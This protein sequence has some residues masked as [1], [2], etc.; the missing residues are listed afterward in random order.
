MSTASGSDARSAA[1]EVL[2]MLP[3]VTGALRTHIRAGRP[4]GMSVPQFRALHAIRRKPRTDL[5]AVADQLGTSLPAASELVARLVDQHLVVRETD[6]TSRRRLCLTLTDAGRAA[7]EGAEARTIEW[8]EEG[9]GRLDPARRSA[10]V[11]ALRDLVA[12]VGADEAS[13]PAAS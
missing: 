6:P 10:L 4:T 7:L 13:A 9:L 11:E 2:D 3:R 1:V 12:V 8:L 5:S